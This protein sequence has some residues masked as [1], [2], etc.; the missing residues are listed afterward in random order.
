MSEYEKRNL[1][2]EQ[3]QYMESWYETWSIY[4]DWDMP[5][6]EFAEILFHFSYMFCKG[7]GDWHSSDN[8]MCIYNAFNWLLKVI[9][10]KHTTL[11][12]VYKPTFF[13]KKHPYFL[14][15]NK[16]FVESMR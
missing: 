12:S 16:S 8:I 15:T 14:Y 3:I 5:F 7:N 9:K 2:K 13:I 4:I 1:G 11:S 6:Q 10:E